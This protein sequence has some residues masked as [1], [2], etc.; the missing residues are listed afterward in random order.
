LRTEV[1]LVVLGTPDSSLAI[2]DDLALEDAFDPN[3]DGFSC[4]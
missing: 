1:D 4:G 3:V 2:D